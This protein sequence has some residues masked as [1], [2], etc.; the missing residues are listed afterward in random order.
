M[1]TVKTIMTAAVALFAVAAFTGCAAVKSPA[2]GVL[3][4]SV[5]DGMAVTGNA[6]ASKVGTAEVKSYLGAIALG[7]ASIQ[8]AAKQAGISRIHHVDYASTSILGL[9]STYTV[10]VYGE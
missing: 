5:K 3:Y 8:T 2:I 9:Y 10:I 1:K 6:G 4:T 7:D